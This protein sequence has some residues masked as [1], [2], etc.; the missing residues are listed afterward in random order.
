MD[1]TEGIREAYVLFLSMAE[2]MMK[3]NEDLRQWIRSMKRKV[4]REKKLPENLLPL[5]YKILSFPP[6]LLFWIRLLQENAMKPEILPPLPDSSAVSTALQ[7]KIMATAR[8]RWRMCIFSF[9]A[10]CG[11]GMRTG[12][13][14]T[15]MKKPMLRR[16]RCPS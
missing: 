6:F 13:G 7:K 15:R 11:C 12:W 8:K 9:P 16:D 4:E 3:R 14:N 1:E 5:A 2:D 10:T